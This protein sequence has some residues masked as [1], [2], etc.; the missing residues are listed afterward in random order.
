MV[1]V[2]YS[3]II[4]IIFIVDD[5]DFVFFGGYQDFNINQKVIDYLVNVLVG[6]FV[7]C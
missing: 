2:L 1:V 4:E 7:F 6:M 5:V 3:E